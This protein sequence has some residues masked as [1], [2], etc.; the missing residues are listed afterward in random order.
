MTIY[1]PPTKD[2]PLSQWVA[3]LSEL[4]PRKDAE[5]IARARGIIAKLSDPNFDLS[6][7]ILRDG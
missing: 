7:F 4:S 6:D 5:E 3:Y 1:D 2:A